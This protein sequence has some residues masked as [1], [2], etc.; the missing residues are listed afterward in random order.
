VS[1]KMWENS[2]AKTKHTEEGQHISVSTR[3][4]RQRNHLLT[5]RKKGERGRRNTAKGYLSAIGG[6]GHE[7]SKL[8]KKTH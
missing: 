5:R 4:R 3:R 1:P 2:V 8:G 7:K 6:R